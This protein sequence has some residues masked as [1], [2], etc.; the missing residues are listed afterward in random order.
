MSRIC[1]T[2]LLAARLYAG[3][4]EEL[5]IALFT[6]Q[7]LSSKPNTPRKGGL[8]TVRLLAAEIFPKSPEP[9]RRTQT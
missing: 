1:E 7:K 2:K 6:L 8:G 3:T 4:G 9:Y 5:P